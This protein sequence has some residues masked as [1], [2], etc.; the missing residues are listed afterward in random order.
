[1]TSA[2]LRP[3]PRRCGDEPYRLWRRRP[4][5]GLPPAKLPVWEFDFICGARISDRSL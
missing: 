5:S 4:P 3:S 1:M 2:M